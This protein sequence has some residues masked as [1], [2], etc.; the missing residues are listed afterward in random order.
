MEEYGCSRSEIGHEV[1][2]YISSCGMLDQPVFFFVLFFFKYQLAAC[3]LLW[4][5]FS[6]S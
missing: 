2:L 6:L 3:E 4:V 1:H 5:V